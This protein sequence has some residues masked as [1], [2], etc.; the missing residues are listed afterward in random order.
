M[1][2][3]PNQS[4]PLHAE[5]KIIE[6]LTELYH[7]EE[8]LWRQL[9]QLEC[10]MHGDKNTYFFHLRA[11]RRRRK[12]QIKALQKPD[13]ELTDNVHEMENMATSFYQHLYTLEGVQNIEQVIDTVPVKVTQAMNDILNARGSE[14]CSVTDVPNLGPG[15]GWQSSALLPTSLRDLW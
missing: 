10:L 13:G 6:R 11:S 5:L 8:M 14:N 9:A 3:I 7:R 12:N 15:S 4:G 1:R 2:K